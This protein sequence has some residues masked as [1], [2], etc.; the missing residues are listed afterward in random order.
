MTNKDIFYQYKTL[1]NSIELKLK[2]L[3]PDL[4]FDGNILNFYNYNN[5]DKLELYVTAT[6]DHPESVL[7]LEFKN[8]FEYLDVVLL[9]KSTKSISR[10]CE[11][12][13]KKGNVF[14]LDLSLFKKDWRNEVE[15]SAALVLKNNIKENIG[16]A[17][18]IG[19]QLGWSKTY[20]IFFDEP[21]EKVGGDSMEF[22]WAS[23]SSNRLFWLNKHYSKDIF[24]L[25]LRGENKMPKVYLNEDMNKH[26][27]SLLEEKSKRISPKTS[28][29]DLMFQSIASSIFSQ[30][31]TDCLIHYKRKLMQ[32]EGVEKL[33]AIENA[34]E[35]LSNWKKKLI[36][37]YSHN[38]CPDSRKKDALDDLKE[39][40]YDDDNKISE[41]L[42]VILNIAQNTLGESANEIFTKSAELLTKGGK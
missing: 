9:I 3:N 5:T 21:E 16:Y 23:F 7:P 27:R 12:F 10:R 40:I 38:I 33:V 11:I 35:N 1:N 22:E 42:K 17:S 30:L 15:I 26:L 41:I 28:S 8:S 18:V 6:I 13:E 4:K 36:E 32:E 20:K 34:W 24:A 19:T 37:N 25:D 14:R 31:L 2:S 29:R 39:S